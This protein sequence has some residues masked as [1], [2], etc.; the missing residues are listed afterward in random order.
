MATYIPNITDV[1]PDPVSFTPDFSFMDKMLQRKKAQYEQGYAQVVGRYNALNKEMTN[2]E[3]IRFRDEFLRQAAI[4]LKD[5]SVMDLSIPQN[6]QAAASVFDPFTQNKTAVADMVYTGFLNTQERMAESDMQKEGGKFYNPA[7]LAYIRSMREAYRSDTPDS[8][9]RYMQNKPYYVPYADYSKKLTDAL[10]KIKPNLVTQEIPLGNGYM[11]K[12][13]VQSYDLHSVKE[14]LDNTLTAAEKNQIRLEG[15]AERLNQFSDPNQTK[16]LVDNYVQY[17]TNLTTAIDK[18]LNEH[19]LKRDNASPKDKGAYDAPIASYEDQK[20]QLLSKIEMLKN[21]DPFQRRMILE[22][23]AGDTYLEGTVN[24]MAQSVA[25]QNNKNELIYSTDETW[26]K[27]YEQNQINARAAADRAAKAKEEQEKNQ[28]PDNLDYLVTLGSTQK[29]EQSLG[30]IQQNISEL[31]TKINGQSSQILAHL[32]S[33]NTG[34]RYTQDHIKQFIAD[35][36]KRSGEVVPVIQNGRVVSYKFSDKSSYK[37]GQELN[38]EDF[39]DYTAWRS[40]SGAVAN[41]NL[42]KQSLESM[43]TSLDDDVKQK[44]ATEYSAVEQMASKINNGRN[45]T[46]TDPE[47]KQYTYTPIEFYRN[48]ESGNIRLVSPTEGTSKDKGFWENTMAILGNTS[49]AYGGSAPV[50]S[51]A[52]TGVIINGKEFSSRSYPLYNRST[53]ESQLLQNVVSHIGQA[54]KIL[55]SEAANKIKKVRQEVYNSTTVGNMTIRPLNPQ[56]NLY[57]QVAGE[58][59]LLSQLLPKVKLQVNGSDNLTGDLVFTITEKG[60]LS[61]EEIMK[62]LKGNLTVREVQKDTYAVRGLDSTGLI[63]NFTPSQKALYNILTYQ[64]RGVEISPNT[65]EFNTDPIYVGEYPVFI[66]RLLT[67]TP[68]T[69][70]T[71]LRNYSFY[72]YDQAVPESPIIDRALTNASQVILMLGE[73]GKNPDAFLAHRE[74]NK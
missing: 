74:N 65:F 5:L 21:A 46:F 33:K 7:S 3:N 28:K 72:I 35:W 58:G 73:L 71:A 34:I 22:D 19:K 13:T 70:G 60:G 45:I 51:S 40:Y 67:E 36:S 44:A 26:L 30:T 6:V 18:K 57:K 48:V 32:Q 12:V 64:T 11:K 42:E 1:F 59:G 50:I 8:V 16:S 25:G 68:G 15:I 54:Q 14:I 27:I 10:D 41:L 38:T 69:D 23:M 2:P 66:K 63:S 52:K 49:G 31:Q 17:A 61:D 43:M 47:G 56:G 9:G 37:P 62:V 53:P 55:D 39:R 4:N 24:T 29:N 20:R